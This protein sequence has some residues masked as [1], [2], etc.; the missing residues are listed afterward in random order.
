MK[1]KRAVVYGESVGGYAELCAGASALAEEV[2][3]VVVGSADQACA[4]AELGVAVRLLEI[5]EDVWLDDCWPVL[6]E[7]I[8]ALQPELVLL[9]AGKRVRALAGRLSVA[10]GMPVA[11]DVA[12]LAEA[13]AGFEFGLVRYGGATEQASVAPSVI[14]IVG[15]GLFA[16]AAPVG[17]G[18]VTTID[19][20]VASGPIR[21][22]SRAPLAE[23][24][25]DLGVAE[26][27]VGVG[28]GIGSV[29][30]VARAAEL[31]RKLGGEL[32]CSRPI[33]EGLG[34][35]PKNR[36]LGVSGAVISPKVYL[37][38][39]ISGQVQHL[40]GVNGSK[41][42]VAINKDKN[43]PI[44]GHCDLGLVADLEA[45]LPELLDKLA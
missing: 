11:S 18:S 32:A 23:E 15:P 35:L 12:S 25:V 10:T 7:E 28:R 19:A 31:A 36:Y 44:F 17:G 8:T 22:M 42:I 13:E 40:V 33:A 38:L 6:I 3:A 16:P 27:V 9:R 43:A 14:A 5:S 2:I 41:A 24:S 20:A 37:A 21:L 26:V 4:V 34:W 1:A 30:N 39:G 45:M 29:E